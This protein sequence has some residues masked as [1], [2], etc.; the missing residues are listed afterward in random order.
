MLKTLGRPIPDSRFKPFKPADVLYDF[1]GPRVFTVVDSEGE[2]NLAYWSDEDEDVARYVV[3]PTTS[4]IVE[5]LQNG[6]ISVYDALDQ[7]RCWLCDVNKVGDIVL[8][9][10]VDFDSLPRDALP[11]DGTLLLPSRPPG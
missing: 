9:Q 6:D 2:L 5:E 4:R 1:D 3:V 7:P 11:D 10:R 8:L